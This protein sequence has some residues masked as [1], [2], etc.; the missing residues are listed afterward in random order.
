M[1]HVPPES[2]EFEGE[3]IPWP[4]RLCAQ[5]QSKDDMPFHKQACTEYTQLVFYK[6][7]GRPRERHLACPIRMHGF[8][9]LSFQG[10]VLNHGLIPPPDHLFGGDTGL[11][12]AQQSESSSSNTSSSDTELAALKVEMAEINKNLMRVLQPPLATLRM[13]MLREPTKNQNKNQGNHNPRRNNQGRHQFFQ[14]ANQGQNQPPAYQAPAYQALVHQPQIPQPQV[15]TTNEFTNLMKANDAILK[16]MQTNMTSLTNSNLELKN[17]FGQ[18]MKIN[19]ALSLGLGTLQGNT[20]ANPKEDLNGITTRGGTAY[21]GPTIPTTSSSIP[22]VVE[23][24]TE[25]TKD[26]VHPTNN[27][28]TEDVQPPVVP[29]ESPILNY[30]PVVAPMIELVASPVSALKPNQRPSIHYPSRFQD[31][32]LHNE[33]NDQREKFF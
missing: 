11:R 10:F 33:A 29:T 18:F 21:Q 5:A 30:E 15:V 32:K 19:T 1:L 16:N 6:L 17:K 24:E 27:G 13:Y 23:R 3:I 8:R 22:L 7:F 25:A 12:N 28:S 20:V 9:P 14:G 31:Q 26:T 4:S 2:N